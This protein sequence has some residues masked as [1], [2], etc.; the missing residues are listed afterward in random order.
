[1]T[2]ALDHGR[3]V[4]RIREIYAAG[5]LCTQR[6]ESSVVRHIARGKHERCRF[7]M[8]SR[9]FFLEVNMPGA[10]TGNVARAAS[11]VTV[12]IQSAAGRSDNETT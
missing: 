3:V 5:Q 8:K 1:M 11:P 6:R 9:Q 2:D 10:I 7:A 12:F 4:G